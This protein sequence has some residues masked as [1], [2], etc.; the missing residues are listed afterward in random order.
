[1]KFNRHS[2]EEV[3]FEIQ[4]PT[5]QRALP[6]EKAWKGLLPSAWAVPTVLWEGGQYSMVAGLTRAEFK[7]GSATFQFGD[8]RPG[9]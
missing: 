1:M 9:S 3:P 6:C 8:L 5:P 2:E 4:M 7:P